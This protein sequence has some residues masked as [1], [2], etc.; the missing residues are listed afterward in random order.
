M[1]GGGGTYVWTRKYSPKVDMLAVWG[2]G[3]RKHRKGGDGESKGRRRRGQWAT[4]WPGRCGKFSGARPGNWAI[5]ASN[6]PSTAVIGFP[7]SDPCRVEDSARARARATGS[8]TA[9]AGPTPQRLSSLV[10]AL[11]Q[12]TRPLQRLSSTSAPQ[13]HEKRQAQMN[14]PS[15]KNPS[16]HPQ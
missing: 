1:V 3:C 10:Q 13:Q 4:R 2:G 6:D 11:S 8:G 14:R 15:R 9:A 12:G 7:Q 16:P 5:Q